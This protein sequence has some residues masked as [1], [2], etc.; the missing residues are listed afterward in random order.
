MK[1]SLSILLILLLSPMA[2]A[3]FH[4]NWDY[5]KM[6]K[7]ADVIVIAIAEVATHDTAERTTFPNCFDA[8]D[9]SPAPAVGV[10]TTFKV[11]SV[12]KGDMK[13][14]IFVFHH[15]RDPQTI[16]ANNGPCVVSFEPK[17]KKTFILFLKRESDGRYSSVTG[18]TDPNIGVKILEYSF[19]SG[20][21]RTI[22]EAGHP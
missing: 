5:D 19:P 4:E 8:A 1:I 13:A 2:F 3:R 12:L 11:L 21:T 10:E 14:E 17:E 9:G 20:G 22:F 15:L 18:Q 16:P 7:Q 6:T